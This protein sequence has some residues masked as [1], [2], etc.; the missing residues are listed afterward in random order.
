MV[1]RRVLAAAVGA[2]L[3]VFVT[4]PAFAAGPRAGGATATAVQAKVSPLAV[5]PSSVFAQLNSLTKALNLSQ[6]DGSL[7]D[8][9]LAVD[10]TTVNGALGDAN[11][12]HSSEA[13]SE[14]VVVNVKAVA[15][16]LAILQNELNSINP[17]LGSVPPT[18]L[19]AVQNLEQ[20][21]SSATNSSALQPYFNALN[22]LTTS[23]AFELKAAHAAYP[24]GPLSDRETVIPADPTGL[25]TQLQAL[26]PYTAAASDGDA[27]AKHT[28][29]ATSSLDALNVLNLGS[30]P[31]SL[32]ASVLAQLNSLITTIEA[33]LAPAA[34]AAGITLP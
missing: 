13:N 23:G 9:S 10:Q 19:A 7:G 29:E 6:V 3:S 33:A 14:P 18:L 26:A 34:T 2:W 30:I 15:S 17:T 12:Y 8:A 5:V 4:A 32:N 20:A 28:V 27:T 21:L 11:L 1:G 25:I 24:D 16:A 22:S 31:L